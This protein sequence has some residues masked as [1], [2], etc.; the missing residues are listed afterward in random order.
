MMSARLANS[1]RAM[2]APVAAIL[3]TLALGFLLV[4][5]VTDDPVRAYRDLL[6]ANFDS[7]GNFALFLNRAT[8]LT[9]IAL[10]VIF[11]FR[12][13]IFMSAAR[14][15]HATRSPRRWSAS[16]WPASGDRPPAFGNRGGHSAGASWAGYRAC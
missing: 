11:S 6:F 4:V 10:G 5:A 9:L 16:C 3:L 8:P 15:A 7:L 1:F 13:G 12:A 2:Y 14:S